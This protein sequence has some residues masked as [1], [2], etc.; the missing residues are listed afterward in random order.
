MMQQYI[1][2]MFCITRQSNKY[3]FPMF[4]LKFNKKLDSNH[5]VLKVKNEQFNPELT[6][7]ILKPNL[8]M[9]QIWKYNIWSMPL[10]QPL[11]NII[12][13][14]MKLNEIQD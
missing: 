5:Q 7:Y 14:V 4:C 8:V 1:L 3:M 2:I 11:N 13:K 9:T 12:H 6:K 10:F